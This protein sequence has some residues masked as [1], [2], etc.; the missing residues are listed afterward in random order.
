MLI[1]RSKNDL[2]IATRIHDQGNAY[3]NELWCSISLTRVRQDAH[4]LQMIK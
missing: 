3:R 2:K 1:F 4:I